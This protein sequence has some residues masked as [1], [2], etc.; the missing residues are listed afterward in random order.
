M[1]IHVLIQWHVV[2]C[3][4]PGLDK[5]LQLIPECHI[6]YTESNVIQYN[7]GLDGGSGIRYSIKKIVLIR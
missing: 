4:I 7:G 1:N 6:E 2:Q 5:H 3:T